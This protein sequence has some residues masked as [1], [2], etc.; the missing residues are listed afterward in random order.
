MDISWR[1]EGWREEGNSG[2]K[3]LIA[4]S[5]LVAGLCW[6]GTGHGPLA[7][8]VR[9]PRGYNV[10]GGLPPLMRK[11]NQLPVDLLVNCLSG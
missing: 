3:D 1:K 6:A 9:I 4:D 5:L 11:N 10:K 7:G 2:P 8:E